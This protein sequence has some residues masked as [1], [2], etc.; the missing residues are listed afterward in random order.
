MSSFLESEDIHFSILNEHLSTLAGGV[1]SLEAWPELWVR[2]E[3]LERAESLIAHAKSQTDE[4]AEQ[5]S[6]VCPECGSEN[7]GNMALCWNC[8]YAIDGTTTP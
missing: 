2:E 1:P 5:I 7:E 4:E 6:W 3:D 8:D